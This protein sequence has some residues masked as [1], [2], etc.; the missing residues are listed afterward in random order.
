VVVAE[1]IYQVVEGVVVCYKDHYQL[2]QVLQS[3]S[4]LVQVEQETQILVLFKALLAEILFLGLL[5]LPEGVAV[6]AVMALEE[7]AV[8]VAAQAMQM[9]M[10]A[11]K[12]PQVKEIGEGVAPQTHT[13]LVEVGAQE[14]W[15][16]TMFILS[17]A[18]LAVLALVAPLME[19]LLCMLAAAE[20]DRL[21]QG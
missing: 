4:Q 2:F 3:R 10:E 21:V 16:E 18:D 17:L 12:A 14:L 15:V 9:L 1:T 5:L 7:L 6:V 20:V 8:V 13:V 11:V 19:L